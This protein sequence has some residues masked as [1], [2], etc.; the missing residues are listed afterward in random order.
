MDKVLQA[1]QVALGGAR[2]AAVAQTSLDNLFLRSY[3]TAFLWFMVGVAFQKSHLD[4]SAT[5]HQ[6]VSFMGHTFIT[7][8]YNCN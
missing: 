3:E 2:Q 6:D 8:S 1:V 5:G 4:K 7:G